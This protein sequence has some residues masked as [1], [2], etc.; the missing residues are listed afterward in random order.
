MDSA[1]V[2]PIKSTRPTKRR[3]NLYIGEWLANYAKAQE[4]IDIVAKLPVDAERQVVI[5]PCTRWA[6]ITPT[7]SPPWVMRFDVNCIDW[8]GGKWVARN[9]VGAHPIPIDCDH[10]Y[11]TEAAAEA[12]RKALLD[13]AS[14]EEK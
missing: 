10:L 6:L 8:F 12:A 1:V 14:T 3:F 4:L 11:G 9:W 13:S 5:P 7:C 2:I